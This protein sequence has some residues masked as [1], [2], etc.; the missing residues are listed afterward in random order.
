MRSFVLM[1]CASLSSAPSPDA[2]HVA[3][4]AHR[5]DH[6]AARE[7]SL[8]AFRAAI[9]AGADFVELDV[10][11]ATGGVLVLAHD[12]AFDRAQVDTFA[13][14]LALVKGRCGVYVDIKAAEPERVIGEIEAAGM[15][16][17]AVFY[18][19]PA[20]LAAIHRRRPAWKVMPEAVSLPVLEQVLAELQPRVVAFDARDFADPVIRRAKQAGALVYVDRLGADDTP[21]RWEDAVRRGADG[22]QTDTPGE[23]VRFLNQRGWRARSPVEPRATR[24]RDVRFN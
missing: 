11:T 1:M 15:E 9:D 16:N 7:N 8:A 12:A 23:L 2:R 4:I 19:R 6:T 24:R 3:V 10:R 14:A 21:A 18:A 17:D 13:A 20:V 5:G 22:I